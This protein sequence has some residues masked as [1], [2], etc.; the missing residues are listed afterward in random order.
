MIAAEVLSPPQNVKSSLKFLAL[1]LSV[2]L[3]VLSERG[4]LQLDLAKLIF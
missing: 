3:S 1:L 4:V 2:L